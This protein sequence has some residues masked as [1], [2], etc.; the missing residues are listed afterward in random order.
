MNAEFQ[1]RPTPTLSSALLFR[2][3]GHPYRSSRLRT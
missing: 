3:P 1:E 2:I